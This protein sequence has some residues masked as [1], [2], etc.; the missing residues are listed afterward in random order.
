MSTVVRRSVDRWLTMKTWIFK[1]TTVIVKKQYFCFG[2]KNTELQTQRV[3]P[4]LSFEIK[5]MSKYKTRHCLRWFHTTW[6]S[7]SVIAQ[8]NFV[9]LNPGDCI[10]KCN[11]VC[12]LV[13]VLENGVFTDVKGLWRLE[14]ANQFA[15]LLN[16]PNG[17]PFTVKQDKIKYLIGTSV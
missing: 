12:H 2:D 8:R 17:L 10:S 13:N 1:D 11:E 6:K 3:L 15:Q 14:I 7:T 5:I 9:C 4:E 16:A